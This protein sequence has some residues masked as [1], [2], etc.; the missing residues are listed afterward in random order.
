VY[1]FNLD[2]IT[3]SQAFSGKLRI[4]LHLQ[5]AILNHWDHLRDYI[6]NKL[7]YSILKDISQDLFCFRLHDI[8]NGTVEL[9]RCPQY[10]LLALDEYGNV[11]LCCQ[12]PK[13]NKYSAGNILRDDIE[14]IIKYRERNEVCSMCITSGMA[15]YF[16]TALNFPLFSNSKEKSFQK[17]LGKIYRKLRNYCD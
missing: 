12:V 8:V 9:Y 10:D 1:Q 16:N 14:D 5:Y 13:G 4:N 6:G 11:L 3:H 2:E 15:S 17:T 7:P